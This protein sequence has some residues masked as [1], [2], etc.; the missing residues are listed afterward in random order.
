MTRPN[1]SLTAAFGT[2]KDLGYIAREDFAC[3]GNCA[4]Y[5][6]TMLAE[7]EIDQGRP[8]E[9]IR[10]AVFYHRQDAEDFA[11]GSDFYIG[12][13]P[14]HSVRHG[15]LGLPTEQVGR[16]VVDVFGKHGIGTEW[17]GHG[18]QR[19]K[20]LVSTVTDPWPAFDDEF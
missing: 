5:E 3:C 15:D 2:L 19:I 18:D 20:V 16:E 1:G 8:A 9:S 10:G 13:G 7:E 14:L 12:Y 6:L 11:A 17:D 4:G